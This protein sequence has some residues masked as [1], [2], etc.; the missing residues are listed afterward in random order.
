M[1]A[2]MNRACERALTQ[3][4]GVPG[5]RPGQRAAASC[6]LSGRDL[7]CILPTGA[8][9]SLC[10]QLP[11]VVH[12]GLTVVVS[13]LIALMLDQVEGLHRR[14]IPAAAITS[15]TPYEERR[16]AERRIRAGEIRILFIAPER[17]ESER[18]RAL[19]QDCPPWLLVVDEAHCVVQWGREFRPPYQR[20]GEFA[21][22]LK[23]RPV[24][25]AMTATADQGMQKQIIRSLGMHRPRE[26]FLPVVRENLRYSLCFTPSCNAEILRLAISERCKTVVFC[27]TRSRTI[28]LAEYL[29]ASGVAAGFYHG[30]MKQEARIGVQQR[31]R[32][33]AIEVL[34]AT[35]AFGMGVDIPDVR[36]VI[37]DAL[38]ASVTDLAQQ[39]GRAGRDGEMADC[40]V[41]F[42]PPD[43]FSRGDL[44]YSMHMATRFHPLEHARL[45]RQCWKPTKRLLQVLLRSRCIPAGISAALGRPAKPCGQC[46]ACL[47]GPAAGS[48]PILKRMD[49]E[50]LIRWFIRE[51]RSRFAARLGMSPARFIPG[52]EMA[53]MARDCSVPA[54]AD[55]AVGPELERFLRAVYAAG[56]ES[57]G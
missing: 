14:G 3:L 13:P 45:M 16:E 53:R 42:A 21:R 38:P 4:F 11:A 52:P 40:I 30:G 29:L 55:E 9:K 48:L 24:L 35:S 54:I 15:L 28:E 46:S 23:V 7:L 50:A 41:L 39:S 27:S 56:G 18:F 51:L 5:Y 34:V 44:I 6:L 31:F 19:M 22:S 10:W 20:I 36:R 12:E 47:Q 17:L 2:A 57:A 32:D 8:G 33:G 37:H 25:C 49:E 1:D 43:V 26:V